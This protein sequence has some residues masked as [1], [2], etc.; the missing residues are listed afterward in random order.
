MKRSVKGKNVYC[1]NCLLKKKELTVNMSLFPAPKDQTIPTP[2]WPFRSKRMQVWLGSLCVLLDSQ[3]V[4][5]LLWC[6]FAGK[7]EEAQ[8]V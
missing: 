2:D 3:N 1:E 6:G 4:M 7:A 5:Y 8:R